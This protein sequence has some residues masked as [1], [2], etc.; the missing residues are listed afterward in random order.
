MALPEADNGV[1]FLCDR[2]GTILRV[3]RDEL[4]L[5]PALQPG[6]TIVGL[7]EE[8]CGDGARQFLSTLTE[9]RAAFDRELSVN[10]GGHS[11]PLQFAGVAHD[12]HF[13]IV[14]SRHPDHDRAVRT[15]VEKLGRQSKQDSA[16]YEDLSRV[17]NEL[18]TLQREMVKK[19][20]E[21]QKLNELKSHFL[22]MA[23]H[24]LRNPL[25]VI[26]AFADFLEADA[27]S[28][29]TDTQ[30]KFAAT[31][32]SS[33]EFMLTL[34]T[35][36][37]DVT[38]IETG[39]LTL[40]RRVTDL[41]QLISRNVAMNRVLAA[42]KSIAVEFDPPLEPARV[43]CD[44]GK[45]EQVLN[46]LITNAVKFSHRGTVVRVA[47]TS[48]SEFATIAVHDQGQGIPAK[49]LHKLFK[50]FSKTSVATTGGEHSTGLGLAIVRKIVEGHGGRIWVE[51]EVGKGSTFF[52]ALPIAP[53][54]ALEE[55]A[56]AAV[57]AEPKPV[58]TKPQPPVSPIAL[59]SMRI[60]LAEDN[61][62]NQKIAIAMFEQMGCQFDVAANGREVLDFMSREQYDAILMDCHMPVM[63]GYEATAEIRRLEQ[64]SGG[65]RHVPIIAMTASS[66]RADRD[67]CIASGMDD[68]VIKPVQR[69]TLGEVLAKWLIT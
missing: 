46:N 32:K 35:E 30:R 65:A 57:P 31:I 50:L 48:S 49:E 15:A 22:G 52:V 9:R 53:P 26:L 14:G 34:V 28:V 45:L 10:V 42:K 47:L 4:G 67:S 6:T 64:A 69:A 61:A 18:A 21:L 63:D 51:S 3:V 68:Y 19:N 59:R 66:S 60:L 41:A 39:E 8:A 23:A 29:L 13:L 27:R 37:L 20:I 17:N 5:A 56:P 43:S 2:A 25:S 16:L 40:D 58:A 54:V 12:G 7:V 33:S 1:A 44:A 36:L 62:I 38:A 55:G 24:D 11:I